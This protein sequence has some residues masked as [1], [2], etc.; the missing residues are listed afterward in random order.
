MDLISPWKGDRQNTSKFL[1]EPR[2]GQHSSR[3]TQ[4]I[5]KIN[6]TTQQAAGAKTLSSY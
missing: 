1:R 2:H 5:Y 4:F 6:L 3:A